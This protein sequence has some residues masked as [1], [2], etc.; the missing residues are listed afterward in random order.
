MKKIVIVSYTFDDNTTVRSYAVYKALHK[1]YDTKVIY[2]LYDH[3]TKSY[4]EIDGDDFLGISTVRYNRNMSMLRI[5]STVVFSFKTINLLKKNSPDIVYTIIPSNFGGALISHY[6][7]RNDVKHIVDIVDLHPES[8]PINKLVKKIMFFLG[9]FTWVLFRNYSV[10]NSDLVFLECNYY[11]KHVKKKYLHKTKTV[12]LSKESNYKYTSVYNFSNEVRIVYLGSIG[13]IYDFE[14][15][16]LLCVHLGKMNMNVFIDI[17]GDGERKNWLISSLN[18][19]SIDFI[20]HGIIYDEN[21]KQ[22]IM[23]KSHFGFNGFKTNTSVGLSY[24]SLDYLD[25][26]LAL[27]NST[28]ED[29]WKL[30]EEFNI[31]LNYK[32]DE[33]ELLAAKIK[34]LTQSEIS[35]MKDNARDIFE[36]NFTRYIFE[37]KVV[38]EI[39][40]LR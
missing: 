9:L 36:K 26:G 30:V 3:Y 20:Y 18:K 15:L 33:L 29:T 2:S 37:E 40:N 38:N 16:I 32:K 10:K 4:R 8:I 5:I 17:I 25:Y 24:K 11:Q 34:N 31:G 27:I 23:K 39:K 28:K 13:T 21:K 6:C 1:I 35:S 19:Q 12:Y 14:S 22:E 7:K